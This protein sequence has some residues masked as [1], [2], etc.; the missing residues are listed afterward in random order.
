MAD[1][2]TFTDQIGRLITC[3]G[4]GSFNPER[5]RRIQGYTQDLSNVGLVE[6]VNNMIDTMKFAPTPNDFKELVSNWKRANHETILVQREHEV[7][8]RDCFE[9][10]FL[11]C[12]YKPSEPKTICFCHCIHGERA[13]IEERQHFPVMPVWDNKTFVPVYGFSK[14]PFPADSFIPKLK[15]KSDVEILD[16]VYQRIGSWKQQKKQANEYWNQLSINAKQR[17]ESD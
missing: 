2:K 16:F 1:H 10:G 5:V 14:E 17:G 9:T 8:C 3:F 15:E 7:T 6:I 13:E 4:Q 11:F 12:K